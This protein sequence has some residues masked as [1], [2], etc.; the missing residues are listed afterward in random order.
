MLMAVFGY[1]V[2]HLYYKIKQ[3]IANDSIDIQYL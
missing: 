1:I 2:S 3:L